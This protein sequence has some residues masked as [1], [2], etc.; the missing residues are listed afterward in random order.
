MW[1]FRKPNKQMFLDWRGYLV[2]VG[3]ATLATILKLLTQPDIIATPNS[4]PYM[5]AIVIIAVYFG[6]GPAIFAS[7]LS[8]AVYDFFFVEPLNSF[9]TLRMPDIPV[10]VIFLLVGVIVSFL[11]SG[12]RNKTEEAVS[13]STLRKQHEAELIKYRDH[14][15]ALVQQR[16]TELEKAN[17]ELEI[18]VKE[19]TAEL[20]ESERKYRLLVENANEAVVVFQDKMFKFFNPKALDISGC[21][22]EELA[23]KPIN[24]L[25]HPDDQDLVIGNYFK[26]IQGEDVSSSYEFRIIHKDGGIKWVEINAVLIT[27][28]GNPAVLG[29]IT[30]ITRTREMNLELKDY[31]QRITRVQEEERKRIA[32][33]LHDDTVQYLS[34]LKLQLDSLINS[35]KVQS[36]EILKKLQYLE[37]D[38]GRAVDDVRRYSHELRPGVL[39]HLGLE[40][41]LEQISD[42]INK[43]QQ[44]TVELVVDGEEP[45]LSED[46]K[47]GFFRIAQEAI[48]NARK[49]AQANKV[50]INLKFSEGQVQ[51]SVKDN[52]SGFDIQRAKT[53]T[54]LTGSLGLMSMQERAKLIGADLKVE[55]TI[56][57]GTSVSVKVSLHH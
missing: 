12:L 41:A 22:Q 6:F 38:A 20:A 28:E 56:G 36:P 27:W 1:I 46:V 8:A 19:R 52:G 53:Q 43:L 10:L 37:K 23:S 50:I 4:L 33:E 34:I 45:E 13:E 30:D 16:T 35:G 42:D 39:E 17:N 40:A 5:L 51:M 44:I 21:S 29:L 48:N 49:H 25:I 31:A 3:V 14:L 2:G 32:Y 24:E 15:E 26:R 47:L 7:I 11:A 54:G 55:S 18:K 57:Q 9:P